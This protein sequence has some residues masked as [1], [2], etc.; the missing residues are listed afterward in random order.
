MNIGKRRMVIAVIVSALLLLISAAAVAARG[1]HA[2]ANQGANTIGFFQAVLVA[3][4]YFL[5]NSAFTPN[6]GFNFFRWP[7]AAGPIVGLI[8]GDLGQGILIG[9]TV[10]LVFLGVI[11]AGGSSPADPSLAGWLGTALALNARLSPQ[12]AI[13]VAAPLG[14]IGLI[15]FFSRMSVDI[16]FVHWADDRAEKGDIAGVARMNWLPGQVYVFITTF[17]PVL[18][19]AL[20]GST[21]LD[22]LFN[23]IDPFR[24]GAAEWRWVRDWFIVAGS[25]LVAVGISINLNLILR[26]STIPYFVVGF[27]VS[28]LSGV[29]IIA[30]AVLA[31]ALAILH[32]MFT[33][34]QQDVTASHS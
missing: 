28:A 7:L 20:V 21:A 34:R 32:I 18:I 12:E 1:A 23:A 22:A 2:P 4:G 33:R 26:G 30:M 19:L 9:A 11:S 6:L 17:F 3:L 15:G 13:A 25:V 8:M 27:T 14:V 24:G 5:T 16:T 29:N 10:N 31:G